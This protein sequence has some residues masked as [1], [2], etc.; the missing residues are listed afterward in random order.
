MGTLHSVAPS[1]RLRGEGWGEGRGDWPRTTLQ[2]LILTFSPQ[3]GR[4]DED[5]GVPC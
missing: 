3:A 1:P 4:R 2:P 5:C